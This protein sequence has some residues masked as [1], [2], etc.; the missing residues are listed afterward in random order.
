MTFEILAQAVIN[1]ILM[2]FVSL[3]LQSAITILRPRHKLRSGKFLMLGMYGIGCGLFQLDPLVSL[4]ISIGAL[5]LLGVC[6]YNDNQRILD[7]PRLTQIF[8]TFG[9]YF[10]EEHGA[11]SLVAQLSNGPEFLGGRP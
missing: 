8:A 1:G 11:V 2:G 7:A 4:P 9:L 5:G 6:V 3:W 10:P